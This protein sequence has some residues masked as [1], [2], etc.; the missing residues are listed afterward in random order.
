MYCQP[1]IDSCLDLMIFLI[2]LFSATWT[3]VLS[4]FLYKIWNLVIQLQWQQFN[5]CKALKDFRYIRSCF[6]WSELIWP[7]TVCTDISPSEHWMFRGHFMKKAKLSCRKLSIDPVIL[8]LTSLHAC[9]PGNTAYHQTDI[10]SYQTKPASNMLNRYPASIFVAHE[11]RCRWNFGR[12]DRKNETSYRQKKKQLS[13]PSLQTTFFK[14][15]HCVNW[16][17]NLCKRSLLNRW[18]AFLMKKKAKNCCSMSWLTG[19]H[20]RKKPLRVDVVYKYCQY[21][22][23]TLSLIRSFQK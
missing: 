17:S 16:I 7:W 4:L 9:P 11:S 6:S 18:I 2:I 1:F 15:L 3:L 5:D 19:T 22:E 12:S 10:D 13:S 14:A 21:F 23:I 8:F 20:L